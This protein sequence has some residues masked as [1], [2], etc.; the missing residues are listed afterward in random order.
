MYMPGED[1]G[2]VKQEIANLAYLLWEQDGRPE[3]RE[4]IHWI[5]AEDEW[6]STAMLSGSCLRTCE[7]MR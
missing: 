1:Q 2:P 6:I 4:K 5:E 7:I 3:G